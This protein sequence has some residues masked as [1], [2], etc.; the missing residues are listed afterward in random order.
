[1]VLLGIRSKFLEHAF[2]MSPLAV[3]RIL[4]QLM[5]SDTWPVYSPFAKEHFGRGKKEGKREGK[6]EGKAEGEADAI[7]LV[8]KARSLDISDA[9]RERITS[10]TDLKQLKKWVTRAVTVDKTSDLFG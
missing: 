10:C 4:E 9:E 3:Q 6:R 7:L 1:M 2:N 5:T 8:L